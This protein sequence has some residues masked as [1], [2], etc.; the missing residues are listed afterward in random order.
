MRLGGDGAGPVPKDP[1]IKAIE[2]LAARERADIYLYS[3][4]IMPSRIDRLRTIV[5]GKKKR[6]PNAIVFLTTFGGDGDSAYRLAACLRRHYKN[7]TV[8]AYIFGLC[9]SAGTLAVLGADEI[10]FGDFGELG[11][12]DVQLTKPDEVYPT[13]SG[14]DIFQAVGVVT[15]TAFDAYQNYFEKIIENSEGHISAKTSAEI[16]RELAVG[17]FAPMTSQIEPERLGEVQRAI[18]VASVYGRRLDRGNLRKDALQR[19]VQGYP[20]HGFVIDFDEAKTLFH[21]VRLADP[22]EHRIGNF[23]PG[24]RRQS[25]VMAEQLILD[26]VQSY[27]VPSKGTQNVAQTQTKSATRPAAATQGRRAAGIQQAK[28]NTSGNAETPQGRSDAKRLKGRALAR[29]PGRG[30]GANR[31]GLN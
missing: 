30:N 14:L 8:R 3:S 20:T 29:S 28:R 5:G 31:P 19:L 2:T 12:L 4:F 26:V 1:G 16:A 23:L 17:L 6:A 9:K 11:P 13:S 24:L 25:A 15:S 7:G 27:V 10:A 21:K 22:L 18:N